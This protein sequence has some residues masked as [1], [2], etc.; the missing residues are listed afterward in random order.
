[1]AARTVR[2]Y[3]RTRPDDASREDRLVRRTLSGF[4]VLALLAVGQLGFASA[5]VAT[6]SPFTGVWSSIDAFDGSTQML[7]IGSGSTPG[8]TYQD[9]YASACASNGGPSTHWVSSGRGTVAGDEL[10]VESFVNGCGSY[11]WDHTFAIYVYDPGTGT[12][13]DLGGNTWHRFP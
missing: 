8:V 11:R 9:F 1:M 4:L 7:T 13:S 2:S 6:S 3:R 12:L 5:V 10:A